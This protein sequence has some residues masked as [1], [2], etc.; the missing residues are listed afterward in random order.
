MEHLQLAST[1][2]GNNKLHN[3]KRKTVHTHETAPL[4][5]TKLRKQQNKKVGNA[6][7]TC[8]NLQS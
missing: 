8:N 1:A 4:E 6:I 5:D 2:F 3:Q 7:A